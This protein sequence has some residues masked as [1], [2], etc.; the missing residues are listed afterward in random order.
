MRSLGIASINQAINKLID[1]L[2]NLHKESS[3]I[4]ITDNENFLVYD[5]VGTDVSSGSVV[6]VSH[7]HRK[8]IGAGIFVI[9]VPDNFSNMHSLNIR[10]HILEFFLE[11][12]LIGHLMSFGTTLTI[13]HLLEPKICFRDFFG[14]V[15][16]RN[17]DRI[18]T[19]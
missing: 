9:G 2:G 16:E 5:D 15:R 3:A 18:L 17:I 8:V 13:S 19:M 4:L 11:S 10:V 1:D 14:A 6:Q 12:H 7:N